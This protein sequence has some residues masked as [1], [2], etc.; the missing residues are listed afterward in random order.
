MDLV[1]LLQ[2]AILLIVLLIS[3]IIFY[4]TFKVATLSLYLIKFSK[5][6]LSNNTLLILLVIQVEVLFHVFQLVLAHLVDP[7][8]NS[9]FFVTWLGSLLSFYLLRCYWLCCSSSSSGVCRNSIIFLGFTIIPSIIYFFIEPFE[10]TD[11]AF[12]FTFSNLRLL[13]ITIAS[14]PEV[15]LR[16]VNS[17]TI[18]AIIAIS[19]T[20]TCSSLALSAV[21]NS[22]LSSV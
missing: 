5:Q 21:W 1:S 22:R 4:I 14:V 17:D 20:T 18:T 12:T 2:V 11:L 7:V 3:N 15:L 6:I 10:R 19:R 8:D 9:L 16:N 13:L